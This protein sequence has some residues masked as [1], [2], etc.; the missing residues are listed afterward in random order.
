M[1]KNPKIAR[2]AH[3]RIFDMIMAAGVEPHG[4]NDPPTYPFFAQELYGVDHA[5]RP[6]LESH[7]LAGRLRS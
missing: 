4:E 6:Q 2:L 5:L 1:K 7:L 3:A